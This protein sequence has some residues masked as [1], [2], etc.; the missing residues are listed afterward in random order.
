MALIVENGTGLAN[1]ESY[2]SVAD[3]DIFHES[4]GNLAW[5]ALDTDVKEQALRRSTDY[6]DSYYSE[7]WLGQTLNLTQALAWPRAF[8]PRPVRQSI[9]AAYDP[10]ISSSALPQQLVKATAQLA[11]KTATGVI[12][13]PDS[14]P[15]IK[16]KTVGPLTVIYQD[17]ASSSVEFNAIEALLSGLLFYGS[18]VDVVR[19]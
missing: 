2:S 16:Q 11:L 13:M 3:A 7:H 1:A 6:I 17:G 14:T 4:R 18:R 10:Y 19:G 9:T 15:D 12:L 5:D 8:V